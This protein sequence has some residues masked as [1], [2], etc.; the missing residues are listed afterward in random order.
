VL[1]AAFVLLL[2]AGLVIQSQTHAFSWDEGFHLLTAQLILGGKRPYL[3]FCFPQTPLN[4]YWN[5]AWMRIF[6]DTWRTAHAVAAL[7]TASAA[8]AAADYV[9]RRFP[10]PDWQ[11]PAAIAVV[12]M[13]GLN[14]VAFDFG[15]VGQAYGICLSLEVAA[16]RAAVAAVDQERLILPAAAGFLALA[17]ANSS[18]LTAPVAPVLLIWILF[19]NRKGK[20]WAKAAAFLAGGAITCLPLAWLFAQGPR[21]TIFNII[22]YNLLYR[23]VDWPGSVRHDIRVLFAWLDSGQALILGMLAVGGLIFVRRCAWDRAVRAEFY[24]CAWLA[25]AEAVYLANVHPSFERYYLLTV[26]FLSVLACAG[27]H[28][29]GSRLFAP[30]RPFWPVFL[31][32]LV[33]GLGFAKSRYD[34]RGDVTWSNAEQIARRVGE[35]PPRGRLLADDMIYFILRYPVPSG[36]ELSDSHKLDLAPEIMSQMHLVSKAELKRRIHSGFFDVV[37]TWDEEAWKEENWIEDVG[38]SRLYARRAT[39]GDADIFWDRVR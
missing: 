1:V 37:E 9:R 29:A 26:P 17:A 36:M 32:G 21:Q 31:L 4:A 8:L 2:A 30:D 24:L 10:V 3:D 23:Q 25:A 38:L 11:G 35:I 16:F 27:L 34:G 20:R 12:L 14:V 5:A 22:E 18:L 33:I 19:H 7:L 28:R 13:I 39:I 6:G 15:T